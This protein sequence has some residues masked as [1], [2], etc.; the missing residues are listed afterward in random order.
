MQGMLFSTPSV[1]V[2][3]VTFKVFKKGLVRELKTD[4]L[5]HFNFALK[6]SDQLR[7]HCHL[8]MDKFLLVV[9]GYMTQWLWD[10]ILEVFRH[11]IIVIGSWWDF[12][13]Y[14][15]VFEYSVWHLFSSFMCLALSK[16]KAFTL[17]MPCYPA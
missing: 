15:A 7:K 12:Q 8:K 10:R 2:E 11:L 1:A 3:I 6:V 9:Y 13:Y 17:S 16:N 14:L 4:K 5:V